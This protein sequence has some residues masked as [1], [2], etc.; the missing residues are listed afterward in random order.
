[1]PVGFIH[2]DASPPAPW[3]R[4]FPSL[5]RSRQALLRAGRQAVL[6]ALLEMKE[7]FDRDDARHILS[8]IYIN[9]YIIWLQQLGSADFP[10][11]PTFTCMPNS[12]AVRQT[13]LTANVETH[14]V[15]SLRVA[16]HQS[17]TACTI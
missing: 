11:S 12:G 3:L 9:D 14:G 10:P 16:S 5:L 8:T 1:M 13:H 2:V 15:S 6:R 7:L 4:N 17:H